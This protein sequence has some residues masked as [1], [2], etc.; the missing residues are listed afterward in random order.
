MNDYM[1]MYAAGVQLNPELITRVKPLTTVD[2][3]VSWIVTN[4][5]NVQFAG[6]NIFKAAAPFTVVD[7]LPYDTS[8]YNIEGRSL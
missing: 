1:S 3:S 6:R 4:H 2:L 5:L 8:R 7:S